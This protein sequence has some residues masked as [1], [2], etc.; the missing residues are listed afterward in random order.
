MHSSYTSTLERSK[1][2]SNGGGTDI[3]GEAHKLHFRLGSRYLYLLNKQGAPRRKAPHAWRLQLSGSCPT[4]QVH[5]TI[6][7]LAV[8]NIGS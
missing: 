6:P 4:H 1:E 8:Q 7:Y 2:D 3:S 5:P